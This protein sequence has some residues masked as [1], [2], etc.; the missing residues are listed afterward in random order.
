VIVVVVLLGGGILAVTAAAQEEDSGTVSLDERMISWQGKYFENAGSPGGTGGYGQA[1]RCLAGEAV[2]DCDLYHLTVDVPAEHWD[3]NSGGVEITTLADPSPA[4]EPEDEKDNF[5]IYVYEGRA[6]AVNPVPVGQSNNPGEAADRVVVPEASGEYTVLVQARDVTQSAYQGGVRLETR[7]NAGGDVPQEPLSNKPCVNGKAADLFPCKGYDLASFLP[8]EDFLTPAELND[9]WG[10]TDPADGREYA[11]VGQQD[12][13]SFVDVTDPFAPRYLGRLNTAQGAPS[14]VLSVWRDM[15]VYENHAYIGAEEPAHGM[16]VFDLR[17]LREV[18]PGEEPVEFSEDVS[19]RYSF[20]GEG[21]VTDPAPGPLVFTGDNSH[22]IVINEESGFAYGVGT[23]T[24]NGGGLHMID[25][26]E[27]DANGDMPRPEFAGCVTEDTTTGPAENDT[28]ESYVHDAQCVNYNGPDADHT[29]KEICF[30]SSQ[31]TLTIVDVT[32]KD[33]PVQLARVPY[34]QATYTHQGWLTEDGKHFLVDD[35]LD[36]TDRVDVE[37]TQTYVFNV[38]DLD[39]VRRV[40]THEGETPSIDHNQY[41]K[42]NLSYQSNYRSGLRVLDVS[43]PLGLNEVG[44]FDIYPENDD[45]EFNGN[46]SNY[47]YFKSGNIILSGIEQGLFVLRPSGSGGDGANAGNDANNAGQQ[48]GSS[49]QSGTSGSRSS[50]RAGFGS[51]RYGN[52]GRRHRAFPVRCRATGTG[53]RR[54]AVTARWRGRKIGSGTGTIT[55]RSKVLTVRLNA[56]GRRLA[57]SRKRYAIKLSLTVR[58]ASGAKATS[59]KRGTLR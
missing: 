50:L 6:P 7:P 48:T 37:K 27:P 36:E 14:G 35:E 25:L 2:P 17:Q 47:P 42:G 39:N 52:T 46:W 22:N 59:V 9:I 3:A 54:C 21:T 29:G 34:D 38:E 53:P 30:N 10:W 18:E 56:L 20:L 8:R 15:K 5:D 55:G 11:I 49:Q 51:Q 12:G 26:G 33:N 24:C 45:P 1:T 43:N 13:T 44:F 28:G 16:Q 40:N 4:N 23:S 32:D 57:R 19:K 58:D 31:D 41:V